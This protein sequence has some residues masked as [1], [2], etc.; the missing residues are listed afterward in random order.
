M[1]THG[2]NKTRKHWSRQTDDG[3]QNQRMM[4]NKTTHL[5]S[6]KHELLVLA[7]RLSVYE[8]RSARHR[9]SRKAASPF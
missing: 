2:N 8:L 3:E 9:M 7:E 1:K 4:V 6:C 5:T